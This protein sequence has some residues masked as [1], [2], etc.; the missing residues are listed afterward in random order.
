L[1][2]TSGNGIIDQQ[3]P[4]SS[5]DS[6]GTVAGIVIGVVL[7]VALL[8][9]GA[10]A[11]VFYWRRRRSIGTTPT[12]QPNTI[13]VDIHRGQSA[14]D[15]TSSGSSSSLVYPKLQNSP[16]VAPR[17]HVPPP[18]R[19][20]QHPSQMRLITNSGSAN[21]SAPPSRNNSSFM[22]ASSPSRPVRPSRPLPA[23]PGENV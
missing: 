2:A 1:S 15:L 10:V 3:S 8:A 7:G 18:V 21:T 22:V 13:T 20:P 6:S 17:P 19:P 14:L 9:A 16:P 12:K 23:S 4:L 5:T 11:G